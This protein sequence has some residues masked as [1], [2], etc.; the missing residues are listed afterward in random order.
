MGA[1]SDLGWSRDKALEDSY[2]CLIS[3]LSMGSTEM[4][5]PQGSYMLSHGIL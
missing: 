4:L 5:Y 1:M 2:A 3:I